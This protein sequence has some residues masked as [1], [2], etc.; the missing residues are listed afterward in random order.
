MPAILTENSINIC[1]ALGFFQ[2]SEAN[3][4]KFFI[5]NFDTVPVNYFTIFISGIQVFMTTILLFSSTS[6]PNEAYKTINM[7]AFSTEILTK[8]KWLAELVLMK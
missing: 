3:A 6:R 4:L 8:P 7:T 1:L 2:Y 5:L